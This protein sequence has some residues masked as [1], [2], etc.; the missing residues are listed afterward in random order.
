MRS[1]GGVSEEE[2]R[3]IRDVIELP[4]ARR[5]RSGR[6]RGRGA[7]QNP[8]NSSESD[9]DLNQA[10]VNQVVEMAGVQD[11]LNAMGDLITGINTDRAA[12]TA[13]N[14]TLLQALQDQRNDTAQLTAQMAALATAQA[15]I[16]AQPVQ[17]APPAQPAAVAVRLRDG[18]VNSIQIFD[19]NNKDHPQDFV[20]E[21]A[22]VAVNEA[23]TEA[24]MIQAAARRLGKA[25]RQWHQHT[26]HVH[27]TWDDWSAAFITAFTPR[28]SHAD[29]LVAVQERKQKV[30]ESG[31][32]YAL[33]KMKLVRLA[34]FQITDAQQINFLIDGL[35]NPHHVSAMLSNPPATLADFL[36]RIQTLEAMTISRPAQLST[37][38][39]PF[40]PAV[41]QQ[42]STS[43]YTDASAVM[44]GFA[45]QLNE[46]VNRLS[47]MTV[48]SN[49]NGGNWRNRDNSRSDKSAKAEDEAADTKASGSS[50]DEKRKYVPLED[51]KCYNCNVNGHIARDCPKKGK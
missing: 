42:A 8:G 4:A 20:D 3:Q 41:G 38:A 40:V 19:S 7:P 10:P 45:S 26:G 46:L 27:V 51:R 31:L 49:Q 24:L 21:I 43:Q 2:F 37:A 44:G 48:R 11:V 32:D 1:H 39:N 28:Y 22:R 16:A 6:G 36:T 18:A 35:L 29:W 17:V 14:N 9:E 13:Q 25:A 30:N 15:A 47:K 34:P 23:W 50:T 5:R 33:T 12:M